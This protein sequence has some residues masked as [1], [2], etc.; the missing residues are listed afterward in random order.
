[1]ATQPVTRIPIDDL[2]V[3]HRLARSLTSSFDLNT[4]LRTILDH[5]ER[6]IQADMWAL[7]MLDEPSRELYYAIAAGGE[8]EALRDLRVKVGEGVTGWVVEHG[9]TLIVPEAANDPRIGKAAAARRRK[10]RSVIA[11]PLLGRTGVQGVIEILN[12]PAAQL[13][14]YTIAFLHILA[15]H[16]AIAIENARDVARIQQ[17]TITDDTTGLFNVRHLY[18]TLGENLE[19]CSREHRQLSLAFLDLDR[20]KLVNDEHGHLIGSELLASVGSRLRQLSRERDLCFRYGGDEFV[21][22]MPDTG[23]EE[24]YAQATRMHRSLL[25][26]RFPMRN[27]LSLRVS[28]SIGLASCP[29]DGSNLHTIIGAADARMYTVKS[30]GRGRVRGA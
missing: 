8:E 10:V 29:A 30:E 21:V 25:E 11:M 14:D 15:D 19:S 12:P 7:L 26:S 5:M 6:F 24:A 1:M 17:L 2:L 3:F 28:A 22:L 18:K 23:G 4:I 9:E 27:G 13:T 16:A 20:F